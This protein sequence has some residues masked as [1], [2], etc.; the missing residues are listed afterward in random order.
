MVIFTTDSVVLLVVETNA[1]WVLGNS[2][3]LHGIDEVFALIDNDVMLNIRV[4]LI[5]DLEVV[6]WEL[7]DG[8]VSA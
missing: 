2:I 8:Q 1:C 4:F 6:G 3:V 5:F 7:L